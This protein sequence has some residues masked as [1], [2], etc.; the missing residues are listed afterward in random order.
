M[1]FGCI[2]CFIFVLYV[3]SHHLQEFIRPRSFHQLS[4]YGYDG[5]VINFTNMAGPFL[6]DTPYC[7]IPNLDPLD[8]SVRHWVRQPMRVVCPRDLSLTY[9]FG[10]KT[11]CELD[12]GK[13]FI[14]EG[15]ENGFVL[16]ISV[17]RAP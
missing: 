13:H 5:D 8:I 7:K 9:V 11:I 16:Q 4:D 15:R 10:G 14:L 17:N 1:L 2:L 12:S 3:L 6:V